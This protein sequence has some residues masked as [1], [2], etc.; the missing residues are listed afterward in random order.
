MLIRR[1]LGI[2]ALVVAGAA[3]GSGPG[4]EIDVTRE[5]DDRVYE[6]F[7]P[8]NAAEPVALVVVLHGFAGTPDDVRSLSGFD[9][10]ARR[11]G[12]AVAYPRAAGLIPAWR[13]DALLSGPDVDF[14]RDLVADAGRVATIDQTRIYAAG[15][16]NGGGMAGRIGCDAAD[17]VAAVGVVAGA[18]APGPCDQERAVPIVAFHGAADRIVPIDGRPPL[19][20]A[21]GDWLA[22]RAAAYGC[23]SVDVASIGDDVEVT[24]AVGCSVPVVF[25][26]ATEGRHGWPGSDRAVSRGDSTLTID[27][28]TIMWEFFAANP[29]GI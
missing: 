18:H 4:G 21:P 28:S 24:E 13:T 23:S 10:V 16:S 5:L 22:A 8:V 12:F 15:M 3:C 11:F 26:V 27:A 9:D 25:Y 20:L 14:L 7:V 1:L 19:L 29:K 2:A 17:L 6:L